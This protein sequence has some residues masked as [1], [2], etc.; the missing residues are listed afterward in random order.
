[1]GDFVQVGQRYWQERRTR[2]RRK[3][4]KGWAGAGDSAGASSPPAPKAEEGATQDVRVLYF[5]SPLTYDGPPLPGLP[6]RAKEK[7]KCRNE[8]DAEN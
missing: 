3:R 4:G 8:G 2:P 1:M 6:Q 7:A 5:T